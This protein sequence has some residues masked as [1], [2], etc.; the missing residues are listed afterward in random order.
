MHFLFYAISYFCGSYIWENLYMAFLLLIP[1][2]F[3]KKKFLVPVFFVLG[4]I[5]GAYFNTPYFVLKTCI[6]KKVRVFAHVLTVNNKKNYCILKTDRICNKK[7]TA[8][9][10]LFTFKK[11]CLNNLDAGDYVFADFIL[12]K[13]VYLNP[14]TF[15]YKNYLL[16]KGIHFKGYI[17]RKSSLKILVKNKSKKNII[18]SYKVF[19]TG[20][21][22]HSNLP[23]NFKGYLIAIITGN[24][25]FLSQEDRN[26]L[27][28]NGISHLFSISGLHVG[29]FFIFILLLL[30]VVFYKFQNYYL[31]FIASIPFVIFYVLFMGSGY[32]AIRAGAILLF[33]ILFLFIK[34]Y[35]EPYT[36]LSFIM[37]LIVLVNP[38]SLLNLSLQFSFTIVYAL[39]FYSQNIRYFSRVYNFFAVL[40]IAFISGIPI[41]CYHFSTIHFKSL[42]S[43]IISVPLFTFLI[44]PLTVPIIF[45]GWF[46]PVFKIFLF[47]IYEILKLNKWLLTMLP[48]L[49]VLYIHS[50]DWFEAGVSY[51]LI[52]IV[53]YFIAKLPSLKR[54]EFF[55]SIIAFVFFLILFCGYEMD[56]RN[57][58][59]LGIMETGGSE[60]VFIK[61][62]QN[63]LI[64]T[65]YNGKVFKRVVLPVL[66]KNGI[67]KLDYVILTSN[68]RFAKGGL[69]ETVK[70]FSVKNIIANDRRIC[71]EFSNI[72][73][74]TAKEG[75]KFG[76]IKI[77]FPPN[78]KYFLLNYKTSSLVINYKGAIITDY[79]SKTMEDY[80][81][82]RGLRHCKVLICYKS[83]TKKFAEREI[84]RCKNKSNGYMEI[85]PL[86]NYKV[87]NFKKKGLLSSILK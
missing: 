15:N 22:L 21:I 41:A 82:Y 20:K 36:I 9:I 46:E 78:D 23:E 30:R 65:G 74:L 57:V 58:K 79:F 85:Y 86:K 24:K 80:L 70:T 39:I 72:K 10:I 54:S 66:L 62:K 61:D 64:N 6:G 48:N 8:K 29:T 38:Y 49:K 33:L 71:K 28:N 45:F 76:S 81:K 77:L 37:F 51:C 67:N 32:P 75:D 53:I 68:R 40:A 73:C 60:V 18:T 43:N 31:P 55:R 17:K 35:R 4:F 25:S 27:I 7:I 2:Y 63:I 14:G 42:I 1:L 13:P 3:V 5:Y 16:S 26:F 84:I 50:F 11:Y 19:I 12:K 47:I 44:I 34:R 59:K 83:E 56:Y 87:V 52:F 69:S